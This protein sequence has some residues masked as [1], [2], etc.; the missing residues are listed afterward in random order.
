MIR[1]IV[2]QRQRFFELSSPKQGRIC[3]GEISTAHGV[4]GLVKIRSYGDDPQTLEQYGPLFT[5]ESGGQSL[6]IILKHQAGGAW[7]AEVSG[8][9]DRNDAEK[10]RGT[11]LWLD[12]ALLPDL[13]EE[14]EGYYHSDLVGMRVIGLDGIEWGEVIAI[15]N[16]GAGDLLEIKPAGKPSFY[17]PFVDSYVP[18]VNLDTGIITID[19]PAGLVD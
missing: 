9:D 12:R 18:E 4:R 14:E 16:F 1:T 13:D 10:L 15:D 2:F 11:Q 7:I 3:V 8:I 5:S 19:M 17:L 6:K